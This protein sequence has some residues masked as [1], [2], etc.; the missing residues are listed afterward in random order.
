MNGDAVRARIAPTSRLG[1]LL[2]Q[3]A[4]VF[5]GQR[6]DRVERLF[7]VA[8]V[9]LDMVAYGGHRRGG[10]AA[11]LLQDGQ[12]LATKQHREVFAEEDVRKVE[13]GILV[14]GGHIASDEGSHARHNASR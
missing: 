12:P 6:V 2:E 9:E 13:G 4:V 3:R 7:G 10:D 14:D 11:A 8:L 1:A 5:A